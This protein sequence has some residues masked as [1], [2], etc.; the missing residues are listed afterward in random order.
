MKTRVLLVDDHAMMLDGLRAMLNAKPGISVTGTAPD[1][2]TCLRMCAQA[3]PDIVVMD[4]EMPG[5]NGVEAVRLLKA[6]HPRVRVVA[7]SMHRERQF[8]VEMLRAGASAYVLKDC[9]FSEL[10]EAIATVR[11]GRPYLCG[12]VSHLIVDDYM[13]S[14]D[15]VPDGPRLTSKQKEVLHLI[16]EGKSSKE[17]SA[18]LGI[19]RKTVEAHRRHMME[20]LNVKTVAELVRY[21]LREGLVRL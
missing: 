9:A 17:L 2:E 4:V 12:R 3:A 13:G 5:M 16:C 18:A 11:E 1:G 15:A 10:T 6:R 7:L 14:I 20:R 8:V 19:S 21:A